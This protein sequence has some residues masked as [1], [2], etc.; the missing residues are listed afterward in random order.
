[1][2]LEQIRKELLEYGLT[3]EYVD[4]VV[5]EDYFDYYKVIPAESY[6]E[7]AEVIYNK[8]DSN[9][10]Y[11]YC[12]KNEGFFTEIEGKNFYLEY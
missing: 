5:T 11:Q 4:S 12:L 6:E 10:G 2:T 9:L 8:K 7:V 1:M 3:T